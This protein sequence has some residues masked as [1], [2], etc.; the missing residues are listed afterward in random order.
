MIYSF[1][2]TWM[3][4]MKMM[5]IMNEISGFSVLYFDAFDVSFLEYN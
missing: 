2:L 5:M 3:M 1:I 4:I